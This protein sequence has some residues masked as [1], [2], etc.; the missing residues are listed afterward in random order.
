MDI[1][2]VKMFFYPNILCNFTLEN[3]AILV[4]DAAI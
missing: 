4:Q 2:N 1:N 3:M